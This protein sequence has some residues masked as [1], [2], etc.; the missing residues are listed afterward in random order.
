M[1]SMISKIIYLFWRPKMLVAYSATAVKANFFFLLFFLNFC[2]TKKNV[3]TS[4]SLFCQ[5]IDFSIPMIPGNG[6]KNLLTSF[7]IEIKFLLLLP[8]DYYLIPSKGT[9]NLFRPNRTCILKIKMDFSM[10]LLKI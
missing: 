3:Q 1:E 4:I 10:I 9:K 8:N 2:K 7:C 6:A 5:N